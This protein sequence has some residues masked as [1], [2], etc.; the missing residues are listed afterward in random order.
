MDF[1]KKK[2]EQ[3]E[4][5]ISR[6]NALYHHLV[7]RNLDLDERGIGDLLYDKNKGLSFLYFLVY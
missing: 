5:R 2:E 4:Y 7:N 3:L 6:L 1:T